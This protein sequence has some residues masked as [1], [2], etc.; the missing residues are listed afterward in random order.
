VG[1]RRIDV[2]RY[3][4]NFEQI[5]LIIVKWA[6]AVEV[7]SFIQLKMK[8]LWVSLLSSDSAERKCLVKLKSFIFTKGD[9]LT[10]LQF[11]SLH[12]Q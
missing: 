4:W 12:Y 6:L 9:Y 3:F 7:G 8:I 2:V 11:L 10:F 5:S 1:K